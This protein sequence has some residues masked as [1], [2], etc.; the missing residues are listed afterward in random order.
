MFEVNCCECSF[1]L[2]HFVFLVS[3]VCFKH[4][5]I[6]IALLPGHFLSRNPFDPTF[7]L[8]VIFF[9]A[10]YSPCFILFSG[11]FVASHVSICAVVQSPCFLL[12]KT[13]KTHLFMTQASIPSFTCLSGIITVSQITLCI[14]GDVACSLSNSCEPFH[15]SLLITDQDISRS[16]T[17]DGRHTPQNRRPTP[18][19]EVQHWNWWCT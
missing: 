8:F 5:F 14:V 1:F 9:F 4:L 19:R 12:W 2:M 7:L 16:S 11:Y 3:F 10:L 17:L 6:V 15:V 18:D 13:N